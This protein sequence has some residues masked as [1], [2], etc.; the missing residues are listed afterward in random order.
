MVGIAGGVWH[1]DTEVRLGDIVVGVHPRGNSE[2]DPLG[3]IQQYPKFT[4]VLSL[5][6]TQSS[7]TLFSQRQLGRNTASCASKWKLLGWTIFLRSPSE[8]FVSDRPDGEAT[9]HRA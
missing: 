8:A 1:P 3:N 9:D 4:M 7:E 5:L 2:I 6:G